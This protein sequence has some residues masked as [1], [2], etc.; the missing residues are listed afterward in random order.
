[1]LEPALDTRKCVR[2]ENVSKNFEVVLPSKVWRYFRIVDAKTN[3]APPAASISLPSLQRQRSNG[4]GP[5]FVQLSEPRIG[6]RNSAVE[7]WLEV[8]IINRIGEHALP[9]S[10]RERRTVS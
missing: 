4:S 2:A 10:V 5:Q 6:Y 3:L 8:R 7:R 9:I 1:M